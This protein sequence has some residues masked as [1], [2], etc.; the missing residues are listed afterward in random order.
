MSRFRAAPAAALFALLALSGCSWFSS[1]S[2]PAEACPSAVILR[3]LANTAVFGPSPQRRPENVAFYG[4]L[5]E[6]D[7]K[8]EYTGDA[9]R[10]SLDVIV[11]G[12]RGPAA[13]GDVVDL[14]Y[15]VAVTGPGQ[16]IIS[17]KPFTDRIVFDH[18]QIRSGV[19]RPHRRVD[20]AARS[21]G[22]CAECPSRFPAKPRCHGVLS[23]F[24][25]PLI[26]RERRIAWACRSRHRRPARS[27]YAIVCRLFVVAAG[28]GRR[29][30]EAGMD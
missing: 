1:S 6:V 14:T 10:V 29:G 4:L 15:F 26:A 24:P 8:C 11:V 12:Q 17:K 25:R 27:R 2:P 28:G 23:A 20:P 9:V 19:H 21:K 7:R 13:H 18:D 22:R 3:S 30:G 16:T 5:S